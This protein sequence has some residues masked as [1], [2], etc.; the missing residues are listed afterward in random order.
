MP[1]PRLLDKV[2]I[3]TGA[4]TGIGE[5]IAHKFAFEGAKVVVNGLPG[6][7][8]QDVVDAIIERG[9]QA[10]ACEADVA[11]H[12]GAHKCVET[13]I[14]AF[15]QLDILVNN[16]G[17][18]TPLE[19]TQDFPLEEFDRVMWANV[20]SA[21]LMTKHALPYLQKTRGNIVF[22]GSEA[23]F[24]GT[25][26]F[27]P[28]GTSKGAIHAFMKGVAV[29]QAK[30]G[31]RANCV[32]PG[33]IDTAWTFTSTGPM[34]KKTEK[35]L[36]GATPLGRRGTTEEMANVYAFIAS[37]EAS[38]VTG[39]LWLADGGITIAHGMPGDEAKY[40][41]APEGALVLEHKQD[42]LKNKPSYPNIE[43]AEG[44]SNPFAAGA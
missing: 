35:T 26:M 25:P 43:G 39:A 5:A 44:D 6:D 23:G 28:Y 2:A 27:T 3:I 33:A 7:P 18:I 40:T 20:R 17:Y 31:V 32:C 29:E 13:A 36:L 22:A 34:D 11:E 37:D 1:G 21:F 19:E 24:N 30:Y 42:G 9:G 15:G 38:F 12:E 4:G 8:V 16:A 14:N 10:V 41:D